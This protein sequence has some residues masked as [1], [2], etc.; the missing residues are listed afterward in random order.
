MNL[1]PASIECPYGVGVNHLGDYQRDCVRQ[2]E[3]AVAGLQRCGIVSDGSADG[4]R[5][6]AVCE[7]S[8]SRQDLAAHASVTFTRTAE[9]RC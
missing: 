4:D 5:L 8:G 7:V 3:A 9:G 1:A 6:A 2:A